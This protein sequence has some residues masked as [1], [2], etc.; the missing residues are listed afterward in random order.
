MGSTSATKPVTVAIWFGLQE[1]G[2]R[3]MH[4]AAESRSPRTGSSS[5][6][7]RSV[8]SRSPGGERG[9]GLCQVSTFYTT[10]VKKSQEANGASELRRTPLPHAREKKVRQ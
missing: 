8:F 10:L 1:I 5:T 6:L 9:H 7:S 3:E 4:P 2:K